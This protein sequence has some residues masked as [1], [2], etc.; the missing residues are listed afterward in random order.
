MKTS[1]WNASTGDGVERSCGG[2][3]EGKRGPLAEGRHGECDTL[4]PCKTSGGTAQQPCH[5]NA[6]CE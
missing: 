2:G 3:G 4:L 1:R 5:R 6:G